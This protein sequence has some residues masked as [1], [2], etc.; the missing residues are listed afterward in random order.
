M[1]YTDK[2]MIDLVLSSQRKM[3]ADVKAVPS[4][5]ADADHRLVIIK[6]TVRAPVPV[7]KP[8][9][10]RLKVELLK[11]TDYLEEYHTRIQ[12]AVQLETA[13]TCTVEEEWANYQ[14]KVS[15]IATDVLGKKVTGGTKKKRTPFWTSELKAAVKAKNHAFRLWMKS[16]TKDTREEYVKQRNLAN[17]M[18][19]A[20][21]QECWEKLG[22]E[23][24]ED[25]QGNKKLLYNLAKSYRQGDKETVTAVKDQEGNLLVG[26]EDIAQR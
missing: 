2:S 1:D 11:N 12:E 10:E 6:C 3:I 20:V 5:S 7:V 19:R 4:V 18:R 21:K 14:Q 25:L 22:K 23:L 17:C 15:E 16:R 26:Q 9:R 24:E 13:D 8:R